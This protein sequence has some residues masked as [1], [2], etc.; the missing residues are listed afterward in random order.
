MNKLIEFRIEIDNVYFGQK[1]R[2]KMSWDYLNWSIN[3]CTEFFFIVLQE[4][5]I[6][7]S[8][9]V[10]TAA[11]KCYSLTHCVCVCNTPRTHVCMDIPENQEIHFI[12][13]IFW[14]EFSF[15]F[16]LEP[17]LIFNSILFPFSFCWIEF[18]ISSS[19]SFKIN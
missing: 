2:K 16:R 18:C 12:S 11:A 10:V 3:Q 4:T 17:N 8:F 13:K 14:F 9:V 7:I 1:K 15:F 19:T 6:L 5:K